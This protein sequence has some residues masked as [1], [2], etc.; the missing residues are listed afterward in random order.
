MQ[1]I[2]NFFIILSSFFACLANAQDTEGTF[3]S[4]HIEKDAQWTRAN[5]PYIVTIDVIVRKNATLTIEEG[6]QVLFSRE[7]R[8]IIDGGLVA[9][10]SKSKKITFAG[11]NE[12][13]WNGFL[14][15]NTCI[16]YNPEDGTG[17]MFEHCIFR[18]TGE[19]PAHLIRSKGCDLKIANC[20][21]ESCYTAVQT[22]RQAD[23]L[24]EMNYFKNCNRP[25]NVRN[26]SKATV[27]NN[28]MIA[29][30]S[31]MLGG[32]TKF[33]GNLLKKFTGKGRHSGLIVW[34]IGGGIV[35]ITDNDFIGF[36][37]YAIKLQ[38]MSRRSTFSLKGNDF[39]HNETNLN[40]SC[41]YFNHGK[42]VVEMNNFHN[43]KKYHVKLFS[44]CKDEKEILNIG[45]NYWG[46]MDAAE[47]QKATLDAKQNDK[48]GAEVKYETALPKK[49]M[50]QP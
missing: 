26:T 37:G 39:K 21:I 20:V 19:T 32:T 25:V 50:M 17:S 6:T 44:P 34:M 46:K 8:L 42:S 15:L 33:Q 40:L 38:K 10:G 2:T 29:C 3:I 35:D 48:I 49:A 47:V 43:Y 1:S 16:P 45:A 23:V 24:V 28:K 11:L 30:N 18:G 31:I 27:V 9:K 14:F 12:G 36:Q 41:E 7:A 5:S 13:N 4:T 22:E